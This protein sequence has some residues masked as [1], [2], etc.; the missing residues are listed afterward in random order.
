MSDH[1]EFFRKRAQFYR[2]MGRAEY[3]DSAGAWLWADDRIAEQEQQ[4]VELRTLAQA[5][6]D[7]RFTFLPCEDAIVALTAA[8]DALK[9][10]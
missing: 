4:L 3:E 10:D 8:L 7:T 1:E 2:N 9:G 6:V 5:V